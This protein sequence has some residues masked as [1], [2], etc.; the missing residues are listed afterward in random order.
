MTN[1][2]ATRILI[3]EDEEKLA[4]LEADYLQNA[5][6]ATD[7]LADGNVVVS[8]VKRAPSGSHTCW[9]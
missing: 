7:S 1:L 5:G 2:K 6:F 4:K 3:V 8:W 9:I